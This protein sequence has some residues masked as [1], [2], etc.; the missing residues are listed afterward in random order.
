MGGDVTVWQPALGFEPPDWGRRNTLANRRSEEAALAQ[1][2]QCAICGDAFTDDN[3][4]TWDHI[5]ARSRG[6]GDDA[7]N[8]QAL[9]RSCNSVKGDR[10]DA[11]YKGDYTD[12]DIAEAKRFLRAK[13]LKQAATPPRNRKALWAVIQG[14]R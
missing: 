14:K 11:G 8:A 7:A 6:G 4:P 13:H 3:K 10:P 2:L 12:A 5:E 1:G 9:C